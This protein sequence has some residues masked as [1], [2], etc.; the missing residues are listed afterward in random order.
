M[1]VREQA[2]TWKALVREWDT[3]TSN[4]YL[5]NSLLFILTSPALRTVPGIQLVFKSPV[6][7]YSGDGVLGND[8]SSVGVAR[9]VNGWTASDTDEV[10]HSFAHQI[11]LSTY[12]VAGARLSKWG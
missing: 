2:G 8:K 6:D 1:R 12:H 4:I 5:T 11:F 7:K 3:G 9:E 10:I